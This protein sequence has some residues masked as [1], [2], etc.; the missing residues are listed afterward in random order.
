MLGAVSHHASETRSTPLLSSP[1]SGQVGKR[2]GVRVRGGEGV[3]LWGGGREVDMAGPLIS[4]NAI[5]FMSP[6]LPV[7]KGDSAGACSVYI[8]NLDPT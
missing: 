4:T 8:S 1:S 5:S 3:W 7:L 6:R 2:G